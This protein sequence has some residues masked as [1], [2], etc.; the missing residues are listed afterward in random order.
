VLLVRLRRP[1]SAFVLA[2]VIVAIG[3]AILMRDFSDDGHFIAVENP[4]VRIALAFPAGCLLNVGWR[5]MR[6]WQRGPWWDGVAILCVFAIGI[7]LLATPTTHVIFLPVTAIPFIA[8]LVLACAG[9]TGPVKALLANRTIRWGG[10]ISYSLYM[11]HLAVLIAWQI[12][13]INPH[14]LAD[15]STFHRGIALAGI[16]ASLILAAALTY[17]LVEEPARRWVRRRTDRSALGSHRD[18]QPAPLPT[19]R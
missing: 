18:L 13:V 9:A 12:W 11:T 3:V 1:S 19:D 16:T 8:L 7:C 17:Y 6:R 5:N 4:W 2:A 10:R 14:D 15:S